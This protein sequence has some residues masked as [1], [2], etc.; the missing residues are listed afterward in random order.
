VIVLPDSRKMMFIGGG[1]SFGGFQRLN[2]L[3]KAPAVDGGRIKSAQEFAPKSIL[4]KK[5]A[6]I[7]TPKTLAAVPEITAQTEK[8]GG[9]SNGRI[10]VLALSIAMFIF[11]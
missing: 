7:E 1:S 9:A 8:T 6:A 3:V 11:K 10:M 4:A 2:G 5:V